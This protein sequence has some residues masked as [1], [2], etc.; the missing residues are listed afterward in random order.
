[1]WHARPIVQ[2]HNL[3]S[4]LAVV[5][6]PRNP[7][8][9][10]SSRPLPST[11]SLWGLCR[12]H[13]HPSSTF[14]TN[15][16]EISLGV[17]KHLYKVQTLINHPNFSSVSTD[18]TIRSA[19]PTLVHLHT[20]KLKGPPPEVVALHNLDTA[21]NTVCVTCASLKPHWHPAWGSFVQGDL[22]VS[23]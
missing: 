11:H 16:F 4:L 12:A 23:C 9:P 2:Q 13:L 8:P 6:H 1:M 17:F 7:P 15:Y 10:Y 22:V 3:E 19:E 5:E 20:H 21:A 18:H 14:T